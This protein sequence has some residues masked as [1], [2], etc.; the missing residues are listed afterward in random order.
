MSDNLGIYYQVFYKAPKGFDDL[1]LI[2]DAAEKIIY[3]D[4]LDDYKDGLN[5]GE[6]YTTT[7]VTLEGI[8]R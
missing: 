6:Y 5:C 1:L 7:G 4:D 8:R 2:G 3:K